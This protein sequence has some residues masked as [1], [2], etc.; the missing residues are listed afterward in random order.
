M[1]PLTGSGL[2]TLF[3]FL[4]QAI[5]GESDEEMLE[6][7]MPIKRYN[8]VTIMILMVTQ[9]I[10]HTW[11]CPAS[12]DIVATGNF[13]CL[14][15]NTGTKS[16]CSVGAWR[17]LALENKVIASFVPAIAATWAW[18]KIDFKFQIIK[19]ANPWPL[20]QFVRNLDVIFVVSTSERAASCGG[21]GGA[22]KYLSVCDSCS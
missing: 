9:L 18:H 5:I 21:L 3:R 7:K 2:Y 15:P 14:P 16:A 6:S 17:Y 13:D 22:F 20:S 8:Y 10:N 1:T 19:R 4:Q 12:N 11:C